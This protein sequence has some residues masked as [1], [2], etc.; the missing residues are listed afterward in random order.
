MRL[1]NSTVI[2]TIEPPRKIRAPRR[3]APKKR[4]QFFLSCCF[5]ALIFT[6]PAI[7]T[8]TASYSAAHLFGQVCEDISA[9]VNMTIRPEKGESQFATLK[10]EPSVQQ[11]CLADQSPLL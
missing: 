11:V 5:F 4:G 2:T 3:V 9:L 10:K 1:M 6:L 7:V 8:L